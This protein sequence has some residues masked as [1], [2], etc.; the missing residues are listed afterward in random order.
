MTTVLTVLVA[1]GFLVLGTAK[2]LALAP[3]RERAAHSGFSVRAY[4]GIGVLEVAGAVGV[5]LGPVVPLFG[6]LAGAGLLCLLAG[7]LITHVRNG[8]RPR[9][10]A[11][12]A[13]SAALVAT[14]LAVLL[15][16]TP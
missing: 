10:L 1:A 9:E 4:R 5:A 7:A 14:Y 8:D 6:G 11:P 3:M 16:V 15:W 12:A 13:V 2:I